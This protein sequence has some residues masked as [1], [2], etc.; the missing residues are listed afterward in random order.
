V[1][2]TILIPK[3]QIFTQQVHSKHY[4]QYTICNHLWLPINQT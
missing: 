3:L 2:N 4:M 1:K